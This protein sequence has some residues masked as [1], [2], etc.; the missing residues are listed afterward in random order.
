MP[1]FAG[2]TSERAHFAALP[3]LGPVRDGFRFRAC[4]PA[5]ILDA[6]EVPRLP[7]AARDRPMCA[8]G[9][10]RLH[11]R[12][13]E[14]DRAL[15]ADAGGNVTIKRVG[16]RLLTRE[17]VLEQET[18]PHRADAAGNIETDDARRDHAAFGRV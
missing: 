12:G 10:H 18:G 7:P 16:E 15:A 8:A 11:F 6:I 2:H 4:D 1:A 14:R 13:V 9:E 17:N 5:A 3:F